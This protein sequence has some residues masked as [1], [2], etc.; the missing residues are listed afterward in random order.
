MT[1]LEIRELIDANSVY[2]FVFISF[3]LGHLGPRLSSLLNG[4]GT[5]PVAQV[6]GVLEHQMVR[7]KG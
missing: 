4:C 5:S 2:I 7:E 3:N 6:P 1:N